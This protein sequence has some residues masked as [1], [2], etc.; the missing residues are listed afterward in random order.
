MNCHIFRR[1]DGHFECHI[2]GWISRKPLPYDPDRYF[3][4]C[5]SRGLGDS[6]ARVTSALGITPCGGCKQ[7]QA[8]LNRL[9]PYR[10]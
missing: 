4:Q 3:R 2:C 5:H 1:D 10:D 7:R 6:V 9:V 8:A